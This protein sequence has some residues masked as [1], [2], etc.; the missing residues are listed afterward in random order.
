MTHRPGPKPGTKPG[1]ERP[2]RPPLFGSWPGPRIGP[3]GKV[4]LLLQGGN[5]IAPSSL[6][7]AILPWNVR[8]G[9][10]AAASSLAC[11]ATE[12]APSGPPGPSL[13][14]NTTR[15]TP[16]PAAAS[17]SISKPC[18]GRGAITGRPSGMTSPVVRVACRPCAHVSTTSADT[19]GCNPRPARHHHASPH[20]GDQQAQTDAP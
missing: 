9:F 17:T 2:P 19:E 12:R 5:C 13:S 4:L 3:N 7:V 10:H 18:A 1:S 20:M 14:R 15:S 16:L 6:G 11:D 8:G